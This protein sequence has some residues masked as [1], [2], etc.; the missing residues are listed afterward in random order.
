MTLIGVR[1]QRKFKS[2]MHRYICLREINFKYSFKYVSK[3]AMQ[4]KVR[5][6]KTELQLRSLVNPL[7][8]RINI[9][10]V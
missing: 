9:G 3:L 1:T 4:N 10:I 7:A 8:F 5:C 6:G 2:L